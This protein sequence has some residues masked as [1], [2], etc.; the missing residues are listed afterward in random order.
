M[1]SI[2]LIT[3]GTRSG[4]SD[5][6]LSYAQKFGDEHKR[7]FLAT[8]PYLDDEIQQRIEKHRCQRQALG[9][10]TIEETVFL[11][12]VIE[13]IPEKSVVLL[14]C[15]TLWINNLLYEYEKK[16]KILSEEEIVLQAQQ[17]ISLS[18]TKELNLV[19]VSGEV[20]MGLVPADSVSR[21]YRGKI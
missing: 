7:F 2:T 15:I 20:G 9:F 13:K 3:G 16:Q 8:C 21:L 10:Q 19:C 17:L 5:Y 6:A 18:Q 12:K 14:D 1:S 4:K 11:T